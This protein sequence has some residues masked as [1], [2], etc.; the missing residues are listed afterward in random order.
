MVK[1]RQQKGGC[2]VGKKK[3]KGGC[4]KGKKA[5]R[6]E[7][8]GVKRDKTDTDSSKDYK[9]SSGGMK[10]KKAKPLTANKGRRTPIKSEATRRKLGKKYFRVKKK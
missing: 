6:R 4:A 3:D 2:V 9:P 5:P 1:T 7:E 10:K 8:H